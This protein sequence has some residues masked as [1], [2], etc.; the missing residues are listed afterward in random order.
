[1]EQAEAKYRAI[2][3]NTTVGLIRSRPEGR[4]SDV[5]PA[6]A[7]RRYGYAAPAELLAE[8]DQA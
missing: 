1:V 5:N 7:A 2:V 6:A 3:E 4:L 8:H